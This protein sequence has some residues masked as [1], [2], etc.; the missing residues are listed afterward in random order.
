MQLLQKSFFII[1]IL[2]YGEN[3]FKRW[4]VA[5][6]TWLNHSRTTEFIMCRV[7]VCRLQPIKM[8]F[9]FLNERGPVLDTFLYTVLMFFCCIVAYLLMPKRSENVGKRMENA[10]L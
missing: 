6:N 7:D 2:I 1:K 8:K 5:I 3:V 10:V 9:H 4:Q